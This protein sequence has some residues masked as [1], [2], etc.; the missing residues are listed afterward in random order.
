[1]LFIDFEN[2]ENKKLIYL[3]PFLYFH[4]LIIVYTNTP[5]LYALYHF[6]AALSYT[7]VGRKLVVASPLET[8]T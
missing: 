4:C 7:G 1:M 6:H 8:L 3:C 5:L 2:F